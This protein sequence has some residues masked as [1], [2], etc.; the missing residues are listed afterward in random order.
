[1]TTDTDICNRAMGMVGARSTIASLAQENSPEARICRLYYATT[2]G[3]MLR[4][5]HW[6]F[7]RKVAYLSLLKSAPGT[8]ENTATPAATTWS[9]AW[10]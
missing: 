9:P 5:A 10:P 7:A 2:L 6:N 8:P 1:M 3:A 4:S